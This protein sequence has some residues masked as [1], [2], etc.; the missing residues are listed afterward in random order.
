MLVIIRNYGTN[1]NFQTKSP[2]GNT[3]FVL[4]CKNG[5]YD[6]VKEMLVYFPMH[7]NLDEKIISTI[8]NKKACNVTPL[9]YLCQQKQKDL[10]M[11]IIDNF[12]T[13]CGLDTI[14]TKSGHTQPITSTLL[15][16][17]ET[18]QQDL[19][20]HILNNHLD[21][22]EI[23]NKFIFV[24]VFYLFLNKKSANNIGPFLNYDTFKE[25]A[26]S[27][28]VTIF[29]ALCKNCYFVFAN[30]M[31]QHI[32][33]P[34][35]KLQ[36]NK[37]K[38]EKNANTADT[39]NLFIRKLLMIAIT[40]GTDS[41]VIDILTKYKPTFKK[42][43]EC[44]D[45]VKVAGVH[46]EQ[47]YCFDSHDGG[48]FCVSTEN[49][50]ESIAML[51]CQ[52]SFINSLRYYM[53]NYRN[54]FIKSLSR[55][56]II[57]IYNNETKKNDTIQTS[58]L[59]EC[60]HNNILC[61]ITKEIISSFPN[62]CWNYT[63]YKYGILSYVINSGV[64]EFA[65]DLVE[66]HIELCDISIIQKNGITHLMNACENSMENLAIEILKYHN[67]DTYPNISINLDYINRYGDTAMDIAIKNKLQ[68][69]VDIISEFS[70]QKMNNLEREL[71]NTKKYAA[72]VK[73]QLS[74]K[75]LAMETKEKRIDS[76]NARLMLRT[77]LLERKE[78]TITLKENEFKNNLSNSVC[79]ICYG[80]EYNM[81]ISLG[82]CHLL[83]VCDNCYPRFSELDSCPTCRVPLDLKK[84]YNT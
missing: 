26:L 70:D 38:K 64:E 69:V 63:L 45:C 19:I 24:Q 53:T 46:F 4:A 34:V 13:S 72:A 9:I 47:N 67:N 52:K 61:E 31:L 55:M 5:L 81:Y 14:I 71:E 82:C 15:M 78:S 76:Q 60:I 51:L 36:K 33:N 77:R 3:A 7:C 48:V 22:C 75:K 18:N 73:I 27:Q 1:C 83:K 57:N 43:I 35:E 62:E 25:L 23:N 2:C 50:I 12:T 79:I 30:D 80:F 58:I 84:C 16:A 44:N 28:Y 56:H 54:N 74:I 29:D 68:N 59:I 40:H 39:D 65:I 11:Y 66:N 6:V 17:C 32:P 21:N 41:L 42:I 20:V 37:K 10:I 8:I 49:Q